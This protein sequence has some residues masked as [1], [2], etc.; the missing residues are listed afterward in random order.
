VNESGLL[1][2]LEVTDADCGEGCMGLVEVEA[3][4][5]SMSGRGFGLD[6][7]SI[8]HHGEPLQS[9]SNDVLKRNC[10][11]STLCTTAASICRI[12]DHRT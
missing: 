5:S 1:Q 11:S 2:R 7:D 6:R 8:L 10:R 9:A 3:W 12:D 4:S